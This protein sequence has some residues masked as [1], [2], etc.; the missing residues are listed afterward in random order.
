MFRIKIQKSFKK[1]GFMI[2]VKYK[3]ILSPFL[4]MIINIRKLREVPP[5]STVKFSLGR[6]ELKLY[7]SSSRCVQGAVIAML[8]HMSDI[9]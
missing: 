8:L 2:P 5:I 7:N 9:K 6:K 4:F 3:S 1:N